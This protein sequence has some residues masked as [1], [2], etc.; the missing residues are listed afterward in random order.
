MLNAGRGL[1]LVCLKEVNDVR[2]TAWRRV[3]SPTWKVYRRAHTRRGAPKRR[4]DH[5]IER[6]RPGGT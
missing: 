1:R 4:P 5:G 2:F 6:G 3:F